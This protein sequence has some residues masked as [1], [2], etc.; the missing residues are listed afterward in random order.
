MPEKKEDEEEEEDPKKQKL[1]E[2]REFIQKVKERKEKLQQ[3]LKSKNINLE[4]EDNVVNN[5]NNNSPQEESENKITPEKGWG[6]VLIETN[7]I[8]ILNAP[9][10]NVVEAWR[11]EK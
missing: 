10:V 11:W 7:L 4:E 3:D 5:E 2:H 6:S 9:V 8:T 1:R